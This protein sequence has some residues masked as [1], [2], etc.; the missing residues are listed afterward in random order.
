MVS[1]LVETA[2]IF[3]PSCLIRSP[4]RRTIRAAVEPEPR[5]TIMPSPTRAAAARAARD[6]G[7]SVSAGTANDSPLIQ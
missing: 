3:R 1:S 6:L 7:D 4:R 2:V 5:P